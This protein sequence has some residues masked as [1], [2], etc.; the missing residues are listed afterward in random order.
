M[1][2][3]ILLLMALMGAIV[4]FSHVAGR[5]Q[6]ADEKAVRARWSKGPGATS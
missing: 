2:L 3:K 4:V 5:R 6:G 1:D